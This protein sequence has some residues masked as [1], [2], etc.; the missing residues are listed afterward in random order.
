MDLAVKVLS[1]IN[2]RQYA[3]QVR[4][5]WRYQKHS[6]RMDRSK[7]PRELHYFD[8]IEAP[9]VDECPVDQKVPQYMNAVREGNF[10]EAVKLAREDNPL[11]S[12]LGRVCDHLCENTCI[13]THFDQPLAIRQIKRFIMDHE[14]QPVLFVT[15]PSTKAKVAVVGAGPAGLA[16]AQE[17][18]YAGFAVTIFEA[19]PYAGGMVG[20]AIPSYRLP[21]AEI[22]QDMAI[23]DELGVDIRYGQKAGVD[24]TIDE[25]R[26]DGYV[27]VFIAVG[28]QL[29]KKLNLP[30]EDAEGMLDGITFL[31]SVREENPIPIGAR[32]GVVGAGDTAMDC[33][34]SARRVGADEVYLIYR[35]TSR[36]DA[37]RPG[38]DP[39]QPGRGHQDRRAGE[40]GGTP[41]RGR[42]AARARVHQDRVSGRPRCVGPQDP[43][44]CPRLRVRDRARQSDPCDQP[45]L[46]ARL[47]R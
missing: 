38:G 12:I 28:A 29:A 30:G 44:R 24:F 18:G 3:E 8:C 15:S 46:R 21:Q 47:L 5:E 10:L 43:V 11:P 33:V 27:A 37:R 36:P 22:D 2:L 31:R 16:A 25:L 23:L 40:P 32:V 26:R 1:R 13:R 35:R 45:A 19:H 7:T 9:C 6:F 4:N 17:L 34:R 14:E 42:C 41:R 20:G 39:R